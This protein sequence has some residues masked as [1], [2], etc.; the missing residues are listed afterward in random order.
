MVG[1]VTRKKPCNDSKVFIPS[2]DN[3]QQSAKVIYVCFKEL[4][5]SWK[6][7]R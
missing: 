6:S 3:S 4:F 7:Q 5:C 2:E 1:F